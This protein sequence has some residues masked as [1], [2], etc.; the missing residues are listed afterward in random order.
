MTFL[1]NV[2]ITTTVNDTGKLLALNIDP[3]LD[4]RQ[5]E[6]EV[7]NKFVKTL[8]G[9]LT[10]VEFSPKDLSIGFSFGQ[11]GATEM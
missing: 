1:D 5:R 3:A 11:S 7:K 2:D 9:A 6:H 4:I 8:L 10:H